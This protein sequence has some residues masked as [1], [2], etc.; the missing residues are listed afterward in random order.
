MADHLKHVLVESFIGAIAL[1]YI[2]AEVILYFVGMFTSPLSTWAAQNLYRAI[3]PGSAASLGPYLRAAVS[4]A[5][6]CISLLS[7]W[8]LLLRWLY[9]TPVKKDESDRAAL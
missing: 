1:G 9:L 7:V 3:A 5:V 4:P 2:F 8:Y 6:G